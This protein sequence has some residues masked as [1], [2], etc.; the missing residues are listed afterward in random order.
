M[1]LSSLITEIQSGKDL[2][3]EEME[4]V[5]STMMEGAVSTDDMANFLLAIKEKGEAVS[6]VIGAARAMRSKMVR[7][8]SPHQVLVD[9]CG[10]GGDGSG[11]FNIS[12][13]AAIVAASTGLPI[14]KHGNRAISSKSGSADAL[15]VLGVNVGATQA[16]VEA[17]LAKINLCFCFAPLFHESVKNVAEAR[18]KLGVPTLFNLLGPLCNPAG[19]IHQIIGVGKPEQRSIMAKALQGLG[20][21][22]S[23]VVHGLDGICEI[24]NAGQTAV[25]IVT[26]GT[27][28]DQIWSPSDFGC[29]PTTRKE[30]QVET[31]AA[32]AQLILNALAGDVGGATDIVIQNAAAAIWLTSATKTMRECAD[33]CRAQLE[34]GAAKKTLDALIRVSNE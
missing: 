27:I 1:K 3:A 25:S 20:T 6:E 16:T 24:S 10:T 15:S 34:D 31:P 4:P 8:E 14:A 33:V 9:T 30:I 23:V 19:A 12:T 13:A 26:P 21:K 18:K 17:C 28:E 32:S 7:I 29:H 22:K 5:I 11:T 2:D